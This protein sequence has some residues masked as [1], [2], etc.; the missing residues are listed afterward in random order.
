MSAAPDVYNRW[1]EENLSP[2][3][4]LSTI[5]SVLVKTLVARGNQ[6]AATS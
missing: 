6:L 2:N 3:E 1:K 4:N 5:F